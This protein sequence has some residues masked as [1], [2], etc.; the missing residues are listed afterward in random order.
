MARERPKERRERKKPTPRATLATP[1]S[2]PLP[3]LSLHSP[4]RQVTDTDKAVLQLKTQRR[5]LAA[6]RTRVRWLERERKRAG[7]RGGGVLC[8]ASPIH[9][10]PLIF[11]PPP[12]PQLDALI[13]RE[14]G[15]ARAALAAKARPAALAAVRRKRLLSQQ[16]AG[17]DAYADKVDGALATLDAAA[18]SA[19]VFGALRAGADALATLQ[20][21]LPVATIELLASD[22]AAAREY[23]ERAAAALAASPSAAADE[24]AARAELAA[25]E[26]AVG[27]EEAAALPAVPGHAALGVGEG[28]EALPAVPG[29]R[30]EEAARRV[31]GPMT[32]A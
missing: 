21:A 7:G 5:Q 23:E 18:R 3:P 28:E 4:A 31:E 25:L 20:S 27:V 15:L 19:A 6:Q 24:E 29:G 17:V 13:A 1:P 10:H 22:S 32:A 30:V 14:D 16:A 2:P 11:S 8:R 26:A 9:S 12:L